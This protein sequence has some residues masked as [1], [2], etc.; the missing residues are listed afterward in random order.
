MCICIQFSFIILFIYLY[1][2]GLGLHC[3]TGFS[4]IAANGGYPLVAVDRFLIV[5]ASLVA[6]LGLKG[7]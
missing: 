6:E 3:C 5:L 4:V 2:A 7:A 1:L